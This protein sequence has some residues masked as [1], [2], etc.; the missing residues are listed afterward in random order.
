MCRSY[1]DELPRAMTKSCCTMSRRPHALSRRAAF[2]PPRRPRNAAK[3]R[4]PPKF[5]ENHAA[6][7]TR[8][9]SSEPDALRRTAAAR[10]HSE[11]A[12][13]K[14]RG[15]TEEALEQTLSK[16]RGSNKESPR[17]HRGSTKKALRKHRGSTEE[18]PRNH[19]GAKGETRATRIIW[20]KS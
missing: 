11:Q 9:G 8:R 14:H 3:I 17:K 5:V 6:G 2:M 18:S 15:S 10:A 1:P 12:P 16:H 19:R 4:R 7:L 20:N 13:R